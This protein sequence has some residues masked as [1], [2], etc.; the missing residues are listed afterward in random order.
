MTRFHLIRHALVEESARLVLYGTMD[1]PLCPETL[2]AQSGQYGALAE[3]LPRDTPWY[4]TPLQRTRSTA[5]AIWNAGYPAVVPGVEPDL[6]EQ[7]L[8]E[9]QG[10]V[11]AALPPLLAQPAHTF[12]PLAGDERPPGGESMQDVIGRVGPVL[13]RLAQAHPGEELVVVCHG[14][15]IRAAIAH[16][17]SIP[18]DAALHLSVQNLSVSVLERHPRAWKVV[19]VNEVPGYFGVR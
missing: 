3:R 9:W 19:C 15:V 7:D 4:V 17:M 16:A 11:H 6:V 12:W 8:G 2:A 14:G 10:L 18:A 1:V 5:E 13:E